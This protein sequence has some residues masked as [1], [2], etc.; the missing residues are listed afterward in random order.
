MNVKKKQSRSMAVV[1]VRIARI[2]RVLAATSARHVAAA[3]GP[4][5]RAARR[6]ANL[7]AAARAQEP[8]TAVALRDDHLAF[9]TLHRLAR[10]EHRLYSIYSFR[11]PMTN[12]ERKNAMQS[13]SLK[14]EGPKKV[15]VQISLIR[16]SVNFPSVR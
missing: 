7:R 5:T 12:S 9:G 4:P 15:I 13:N 3:A 16:M 14:K 2:A 10:V 1:T 6:P 8:V 11:T